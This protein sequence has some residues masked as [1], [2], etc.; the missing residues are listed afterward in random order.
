MKRRRRRK[1]RYKRGIH[2]SS[3]TGQHCSYR[4]GWELLLLES[5]D[6]DP[7]VE[8]FVYEGIKIPYVSNTRSGKTRNYIPDFFVESTSGERFLIEIKP[9]RKLDQ[10]TV[11]KKLKAAGQWCRAS[12]VTL[13]VLTEVELKSIGLLK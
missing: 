10:A 8:A 6:V 2:I 4:S 1:G 11:V 9:K 13:V 3:K 5:L 12:G 7:S